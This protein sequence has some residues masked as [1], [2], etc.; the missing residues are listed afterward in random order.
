MRPA[1]GSPSAVARKPYVAPAPKTAGARTVTAAALLTAQISGQ[2]DLRAGPGQEIEAGE[3]VDTLVYFVP[4]AGGPRAKPIHFNIYT[5]HRDFNPEAVA[6]PLGS[7]VTFVNLDSVRHNVFSVTPGAAFNLG[8][9]SAGKKAPHVFTQAGLVLVSCNVHHS[10]EL[11]MLVIP[12]PYSGRV[13]ADGSFTLGGLPPGAG[14][15]HFWNPRALL[16]SQPVSLPL[17]G[18][19]R[20]VLQAIKP[21]M[22]TELN[23]GVAP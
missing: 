9:Q 23:V 17:R 19:V 5:H 16:A 8:Y 15:L 11:D 22:R 13:A 7:T 20:Q 10:M 18:T 6:V 2:V 12:T 3:V 21:R 4:A 1:R 14:T